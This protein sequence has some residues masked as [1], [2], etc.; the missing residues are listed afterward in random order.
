MP[1]PPN[2]KPEEIKTVTEDDALFIARVRIIRG[3]KLIE[4]LMSSEDLQ[5]T[6]LAKLSPDEL[7]NLNAWLDPSLGVDGLVTTD[8]SSL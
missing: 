6:G 1:P 3:Q 4:Q 2:E 5:R 8:S 7:G